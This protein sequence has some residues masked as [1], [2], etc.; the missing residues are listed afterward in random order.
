MMYRPCFPFDLR[1]LSQTLLC[2][3]FAFSA[4]GVLAQ[5][6]VRSEGS[7]PDGLPVE[8]VERLAPEQLVAWCIVPFDASKRGPQQRAEMLVELGM[9][10]CAYDW[11]AEHVETFEEEILAYREQ[12]IEFFAFWGVHDEAFRLFAK[13]DLHP[14]I[15]LTLG[16][17]AGETQAEKVEAAAQ[18]LVPVAKRTA[19]LNLPF[20]LYNHGGWGG[21]PEN[22]VAVCQRLHELGFPH[23]GIVYN[24]HHGHDAIDDWERL[25]PLMQ[26]HLLCLNING[27]NPRAEPK[28]LGLAQGEHELEMIR[29]ALA[30]GY[31]GPI[32]ILDHRVELDAK[33][34]LQENLDGLKWIRQEL[35]DPGSAGEPPS[36]PK[37]DA[38]GPHGNSSGKRVP[39]KEVYRQ[40]PLTVDCQV[41]LTRSDVY[42][43]LVASDTKASADH[44]E[45]FSMLGTGHLTVYLPGYQ[46]DHVRSE[47]SIC[48]G[49]SHRITMTYESNR[50]R[51]WV[52]G[53]LV[54]DQRVQRKSTRSVPGE[55]AIGRLVAGPFRCT[56]KIDWVW[57]RKGVHPP[58]PQQA[59]S[60]KVTR[61]EAE[62]AATTEGF[63]E[64]PQVTED[65][66]SVTPKA[67]EPE[68]SREAAHHP[69]HEHHHAMEATETTAMRAIPEFDPQWVE[70]LVEQARQLG[71]ARRGARVFA[72]AKVACLSCHQ[73]GSH[74][75]EIGPTL[76]E[77]ASQRQPQQIVE[78]LYWP[79]RQ[80]EP[81]YVSWQL[82]T[83][84]G[85][86][87]SGF[88]LAE[89]E[90]ELVLHEI[91]SGQQL[92]FERDEIEDEVPGGSPMPADLMTALTEQ[93]QLDL[94]AFLMEL[95]FA[96]RKLSDRL[97]AALVQAQQHGPVEFTYTRAPLQPEAWPHADHPV[98]QQRLYDFYLKQADYFRRWQQDQPL[99]MVISA[100]PGLDGGA[101]GHWGTQKEQDWADAR[102]NQTE[103]GSL[104]GGV[105][106]FNGKTVTRA[107]CVH[108]GGN[109]QWSTCFD[110]DTCKYRL[111]W[112]GG[113][114]K[115]SPVRHGFIDGLSI[116]G[117]P[118]RVGYPGRP[119]GEVEYV[120]LYRDGPQVIFAYRLNGDLWLDAPSI[121]DGEFSREVAP[122]A[123]HSMRHVV[124]GGKPQ[125]PESI[126]T[127][128]RYGD[129]RPY[130]ID[131]IELPWDNPWNALL[132]CG[133]HD[134]LPDGSALV[135]TMQGDVWHVT[136]FQLDSSSARPTTARW[137]RFAS[138]LH[139]A[140]GLVVDED[141]IFVQCRDQLVRLHDRNRDGEADFYE[142]YSKAFV[143][144]P[145]GHDYICGLQRDSEGNFLLASGNQGLV[146]ITS[147]GKRAEVLATGFRNP[148]GL[149]VLPD[150]T[151]TVPCSEGEWTPASMICAV[152][153]QVPTSQLLRPEDATQPP[154]YGYQ[155]PRAGK[156][157]AVPLAYLPRGLDNSSGG[158][159]FVESQ[160]WGPL[161]GQLLHLSFG[162]GRLFLVLR[163]EVEGLQQG[164][165]VPLPGDFLSGIHR[166]RFHP[167]DGQLY[168]SGMDGW[169]SFTP[170]DGCFQRVRYTGAEVQVPV[171]FH[172]HQNGVR[173][174]FSQPLAASVEE[175]TQ[176]FAQAW[177]YRYSSGYGSPELSPSHPGVVG[178]D[179]LEIESVTRLADGRS[180]FVEIPGLQPVNQLH[181]AIQ[182]DDSSDPSALSQLFVTAHR[183]DEPFEGF[184]SYQPRPK[185]VAAHPLLTDMALNEL[186][187][188]N[189]FQEPLE[190]A[191][192]ITLRTG[193]NLSYETRVLRVKARE[194]LKLTLDN[195]DV[196]P[197]N[198]VLA[199]PG[200]LATVGELAN[201]MIADPEAVARQ[202]VPDSPEILAYTDVVPPKSEFTIFFTAPAKPGRYPFLCTFPGHWMVMNGELI[203]E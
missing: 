14:Q 89:S 53:R 23:V 165:V 150:G 146:R 57:L 16:E 78:S 160:Q 187:V 148:D 122:I 189:P 158:Q 121:V 82:L 163:D 15:W 178:H 125:W 188:P 34:S 107:M 4:E 115:S 99:P 46:P 69:Q 75:G 50:V 79:Q 155:G 68:T 198:W 128:I 129:E 49:Q 43:I 102:W 134:F 47:V 37:L 63:W 135:C 95:D 65:S 143:T 98:N 153:P 21:R 120:G 45:I 154:H 33:Q 112:Q 70:Q 114:V 123:Q 55:F 87:F 172:L 203:V 52:D 91:S 72:D 164:A 60:R 176:H 145:A 109:E 48:D 64:F 3:L 111:F 137:R 35:I 171:D 2:V 116:D 67:S 177:N 105:L 77:I 58:Q 88:K 32:G 108:L 12:G 196:V 169:V 156:A 190:G 181:L 103:L 186:Q 74:G 11:R 83:I 25:F 162:M 42:N 113:F 44:W 94:I 118:V 18:S 194:P 86:V 19:D 92:R 93:Q 66:S 139:H 179:P 31:R 41:Q 26:P 140:L 13:Y 119:D 192:A 10:R 40:P 141:G 85:K 51:L 131:T 8:V 183:L 73:V 80:V 151:I 182:A 97:D 106:R 39:G 117:T 90:E 168:V 17:G 195:P 147:D 142:C 175:P 161:A 54:A 59:A 132:F 126:E 130:A 28:I 124:D 101:F 30:S 185:T 9:R 5:D 96:D 138:G 159:V 200:Q 61:Q 62:A 27:M 22:L 166:G 157:P 136:G 84:D 36:R 81:Q 104:Q 110:L 170:E 76:T 1:F 29:F 144:S 100:F 6:A 180:L 149:G 71:R 56:G 173:I 184:P 7:P 197:H 201:R 38:E 24:F 133:G 191:R 20:G 174:T 193:K 152:R 199:H 127:S 167:Q 202:Y